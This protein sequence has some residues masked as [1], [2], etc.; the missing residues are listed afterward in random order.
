MRNRR[1]LDLLAFCGYIVSMEFA[2][3]VRDNRERVDLTQ[4]ELAKRSGL[5]VNTIAN[6]ESGRTS[7]PRR[8][9]RRQLES[10]F[11]HKYPREVQDGGKVAKRDPARKT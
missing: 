7:S 10:V 2:K 1:L 6:Y 3:W 5:H 4:D 11:G 9:A 8:S